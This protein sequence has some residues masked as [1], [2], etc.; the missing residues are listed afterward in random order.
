VFECSERDLPVTRERLLRF[1][2]EANDRLA[3]LGF[4]LCTGNI[5]ARNPDY[6]LTVD[7]WR[8]RFAGWMREPTPEAL[9]AANIFFD[10]RPLAGDHTLAERLRSW[11]DAT[12]GENKL[13]LRMLVANALQAEP[14]L[15]WIRTFR[16]DEGEFAGTIDLKTHGTRIFV[17]AARAFALALGIGETN[18]SQR[19]RAAGRR[20]NRDEREIAASVDAYHFLQL[21]RLRAQRGGLDL[22]ATESASGAERPRHALNRLDPYALNEID[23]RMLRE[24]FRQARAL[25][26]HLDQAVGH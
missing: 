26:T 22:A 11:L 3:E 8:G 17:D 9:L 16:T 14:P 15:G 25:Q 10:F 1:A 23:Q 19:I 4:P 13:F 18:T 21:L 5:M 24:A 12:S 2:R 6:C 20:L 7:E